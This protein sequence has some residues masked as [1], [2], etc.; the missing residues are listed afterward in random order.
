MQQQQTTE[1]DQL[2]DQLASVI[3][4]FEKNKSRNI[5]YQYWLA[6][7]TFFDGGKWYY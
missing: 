4:Q 7:R 6:Y 2:L 1:L 5:R 3:P